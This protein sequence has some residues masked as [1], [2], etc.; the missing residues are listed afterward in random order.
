[1]DEEQ[2]E[3]F[4]PDGDIVRAGP[5]YPAPDTGARAWARSA[6]WSVMHPRRS[7]EL[8]RNITALQREMDAER[9]REAERTTIP[10]ALQHP[11]RE[12]F[13]TRP[14][15]QPGREASPGSRSAGREAGS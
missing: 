12:A 15:P 9:S 11:G 14:L 1:M 3:D 8:N 2:H 6:A 13:T 7:A 4:V 5:P 10:K